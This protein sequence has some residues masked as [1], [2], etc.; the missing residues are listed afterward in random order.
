M[1]F[2]FWLPMIVFSGLW[3]VAQ[4]NSLATQKPTAPPR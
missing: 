3:S 4:E 2:L 1:P